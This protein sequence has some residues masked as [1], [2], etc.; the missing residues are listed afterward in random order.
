MIVWCPSRCPAIM[1]PTSTGDDT[2]EAVGPT[3]QLK[4]YLRGE[5]LILSDFMPILENVGLRV[6]AVTPYEIR[7]AKAPAAVIYS[8]SVQDSTASPLDVDDQG[9][10][11]ADAILAVRRGDVTNDELNAL[12]LLV[13][14]SWREVDVLRAY[15]AY[16]FQIGL[17]PSRLAL[18]T[19]LLS[20][21]VSH[22][23]SSIFSRRNS[24]TPEGPSRAEGNSSTI[25]RRY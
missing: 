2:P 3:T 23:F 11:L 25:S 6:I 10:L 4:L 5:R 15:A 14:L 7:G 13:G 17:V 18:P 8:F 16:A 19:A 9:T 22:A 20:I 21:R 1:E 12:V 24:T